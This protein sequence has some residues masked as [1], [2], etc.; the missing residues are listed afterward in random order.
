MARDLLEQAGLL[1]FEKG[2]LNAKF[3]SVPASKAAAAAAVLAQAAAAGALQAG[4]AP[5]AAAPPAAATAAAAAAAAARG[6][7]VVKEEWAGD[8]RAEGPA[9]AEPA[10][11]MPPSKRPR[12]AEV[13][14][15]DAQPQPQPQPQQQQQQWRQQQQQ[16]PSG[17]IPRAGATAPAAA[18]APAGPRPSAGAAGPPPQLP[19]PAAAREALAA[20]DADGPA[21]LELTMPLVALAEWAGVGADQAGCGAGGLHPALASRIRA[22]A[23]A[24]ARPQR[25][26]RALRPAPRPP[27]RLC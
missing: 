6:S 19:D 3:W 14:P 8:E 22:P 9:A 5:A 7:V 15:E 11:A 23:A 20:S 18:G 4:G 25:A 21:L 16:Q 2:G 10:Q 27:S 17:L 1:Q 24:V 26:C 13:Q 12:G